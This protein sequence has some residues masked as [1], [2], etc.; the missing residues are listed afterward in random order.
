[1]SAQRKITEEQVLWLRK[2]HARPYPNGKMKSY[3]TLAKCV[4]ISA[5]H[6]RDIIHG[7]RRIISTTTHA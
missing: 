2:Q 4:G 6:A 5:T 3:A 7:K 1:M